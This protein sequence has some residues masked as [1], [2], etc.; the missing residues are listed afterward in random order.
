MTDIQHKS[1]AA[2]SAPGNT[3]VLI[4]CGQLTDRR[5]PQEAASPLEL[6]SEAARRAAADAGP[7][8]ALLQCL[9]RV[10]A[11]GMTVDS[12]E[13]GDLGIQGYRNVPLSLCR[14]L[15]I[16]PAQ[17]L[18]GTT[19]GNTPQMLVNRHAEQIARGACSAVLL[20]GA[21][22]LKA[23]IGRLLQGLDID[24]WQ[25]DA[26]EDPARDGPERLPANAHEV[27]HGLQLPASVYPLFENALRGKYGLDLEQHRRRMG[28]LFHPFTRV[29]A[30]NPLAW[31]PVERSAAELAEPGDKNR[32]VGFPY[33]KYLN[34]IIEVNMG[35][36]V[37]MT[38]LEKARELGVPEERMVYLHGCGDANELW[39]LSERVDYSSSPALRA[40]GR[41]ALA[42]AG[43]T[44]ADMDF[45]DL[46]SCFPCAVQIACDELGIAWN[47]PRGL[48]LTGGLPYFGGPGNNYVLHA[49]AHMMAR[50]REHPGKF[51]LLN[52]NGWFLTK[53]SV[54]IYSTAPP[55]HPW[56]RRD[57]AQYQGEILEQAHP[58]FTET[59]EGPA[60]V[61]TYTVLNGHQGPERGIVIGRL[62]DGTRFIAETPDDSATLQAMMARDMLGAAGIA[63]S[64]EGKNL[65]VPD[66]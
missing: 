11:I 19:G 33:T 39:H 46:Y 36:A 61:E 35:A 49:I 28:E 6:M 17:T 3:P 30:A 59:P 65:F 41:E 4:G 63:S 2:G 7:G 55:A 60:T 40:A 32:Y 9:D 27:A 34:A 5:P 29:A 42:M 26:G 45:L 23:M 43:K 8:D 51:G 57:P 24:A 14:A 50:L 64:R 1:S 15:G 13:T 20:A 10:V 21:E 22:A 18:Y 38:S 25:L 16:A 56:Q 53:H 47:D 48:T 58:A 44:I 66:A 12:P 31:F 37:I 54:G 62:A 52:A